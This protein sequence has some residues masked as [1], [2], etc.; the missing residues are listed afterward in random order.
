VA[1]FDHRCRFGG[2]LRGRLG[3]CLTRGG[4][5]LFRGF[6]TNHFI[7]AHAML[8]RELLHTLEQ[9]LLGGIGTTTD[10]RF[11]FGLKFA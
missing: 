2:F 6:L 4:C 5:R 8:C 3:G 11:H 7:Q 9:I 10:F 1:E